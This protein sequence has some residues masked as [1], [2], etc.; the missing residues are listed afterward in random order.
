L[1]AQGFLLGAAISACGQLAKNFSHK[2]QKKL[3][4]KAPC[5]V[6][7]AR[8]RESVLDKVNLYIDR[9]LKIEDTVVT[10]SR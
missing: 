9:L 7:L 8:A 6:C 5:V 10:I 3:A 2:Q 4:I 1:I